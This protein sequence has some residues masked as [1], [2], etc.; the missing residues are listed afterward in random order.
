MEM[1]SVSNEGGMT[2][3]I[4]CGFDCWSLVGGIGSV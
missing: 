4:M 2:T 3:S 1:D